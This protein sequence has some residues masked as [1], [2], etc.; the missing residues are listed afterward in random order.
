MP[1][2]SPALLA[3]LQERGI[4]PVLAKKECKEAR[5]THNGKRYFAIAFPNMSGGYEI[6]NQYFK[7]CIAPK[8]ITHIRQQEPKTTCFIFEGFMDY[9]SFL[10]L[11]LESC[12]QY[13]DFDRQDYMVLNSVANVSKALYPLGSYERIH[14]FLTM[15]V[16]EWKPFSKSARNM[17]AHGI[18]GTL[19]KS[20]ADAKT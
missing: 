1:L 3:Y 17:K 15:T 13:P 4:N 5:F 12:P 2:S 6:R 7:G 10:T 16:Q 20:T 8:A 19:H 9:L 18:Y 11:R 14:C